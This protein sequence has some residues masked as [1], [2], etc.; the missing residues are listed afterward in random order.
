[1]PVRIE[2]IHAC[3][4]GS[5]VGLESQNMYPHH[6]GSVHTPLPRPATIPEK[7]GGAGLCNWWSH[8]RRTGYRYKIL[9]GVGHNITSVQSHRIQTKV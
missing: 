3:E 9:S 6:C 8:Y 5:V 1:V 2:D 4:V 7:R